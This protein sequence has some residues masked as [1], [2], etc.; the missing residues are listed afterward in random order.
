M[1]PATHIAPFCPRLLATTIARYGQGSAGG[2]A[3]L[4]LALLMPSALAQEPVDASTASSPTISP[5]AHPLDWVPMED[6]SEQQLESMPLGCCGAYVPPVRTDEDANVDPAT[7]SVRAKADSSETQ[8]Q[9][10]I[11]MQGNVELTQGYR[12]LRADEATFNQQTRQADITGEVELREPGLLLRADTATMSMDSGDASLA[13]AEFVLYESRVRGTA[14]RLE[15][16]GDNIIVLNNSRITSCEPD[17]N[18]WSIAGSEVKINQEKRYGTAKHMRLNIKDI[19][20]IYSPYIRFPVGSD[21]LTGFLFPSISF[22]SSSGIEDFAAPFYWNLAPNYDVLLTPRYVDRHGTGLDVEFRHMSE[23]FDTILDTSYIHNDEGDYSARDLQKIEDGLRAD[24]TDESRWMYTFDQIGGRGQRWSTKID[25]SDVSDI[26]FL[27]DFNRSGIDTNRQPNIVKVAQADYH[28]DNWLFS[29][30][31]QEYLVLTEESQI[32]Y[33]ELP[34]VKADGTYR[35]GDW[36]V[37][38]N[39]EY[40]NFDLNSNYNLPTNNL[41]LGER[42]RTDYGLTWDK[43]FAWG[44]IKPGVAVKS[45]S[46]RLDSEALTD[47]ANNSPSLVVPQA[48]LDAGLYFERDT[49]LFNNSFTQTLEPRAFYFYSDY[50]DHSKFYGLTANN[51]YINFDSSEMTFTYDQLFRDTRFSGGDRIDDANQVA[52]G[53]SSALISSATGIERLRMSVGQIFYHGD[54]RVVIANN[55]ADE[56]YTRPKSE[57]A[58]QIK[59]QIGDSLRFK[60]DV[61]YNQEQSEVSSASLSMNYMDDSYRI[62][63]VSYRYTRNPQSFNPSNPAPVLDSTMDQIDV[64][65]I[66][67]I[68]AQWSVIARSNYDFTYNLELDTFAGLE[69]SDCC[70]RIRIL[71]RRWLNFDYNSNFLKTAT[72]DDYDEGIFVDIQLK[73][74]GS[75]SKRIGNLLDEAI[76]G[77]NDREESLR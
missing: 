37:K 69:Y 70:Y 8:Q 77:Y 2:I 36:A 57:L 4:S 38:L 47:T 15:K 42:L 16:F 24:Y 35:L 14:K 10:T 34:R 62:L 75:I 71:G 3:V 48:T 64:S 31:G 29:A 6:L 43:D 7:A 50:E 20:V 74:L 52:V 23:Q 59:G 63:N 12:S 5:A 11:I 28:S 1:A 49:R 19:P 9:T 61:A 40:V 44:F 30:K 76:F 32:P 72:R 26:D 65:T 41:I 58:A 56:D 54:R 33:R 18:L 39:H 60:S 51:R 73:G 13:D 67:P 46:Y 17:S 21:R 22:D 66:L 55:A 27:R 53:L 68:S 45:L 25:Y